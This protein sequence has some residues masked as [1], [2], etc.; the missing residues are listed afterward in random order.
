MANDFKS[1]LGR[2]DVS[3]LD[4]ARGAFGQSKKQRKR[5]RLG[6]AGLFL[7]DLWEANKLSKVNKNLEA[8][9]DLW[10]FS[11]NTIPYYA[12]NTPA[13]KCYE[14]NFEGTMECKSK[15]FVCPSCGN[16]DQGRMNVIRRVS[17]YLGNPNT[18]PFNKGK[19]KECEDRV[20]NK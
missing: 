6:M 1:L 20:T 8:L 16:S 7:M 17:G 11:Y 2:K 12:I 14:C 15:G 9:E 10:D 4:L 18:R 5:N 19:S 13:D 3:Y